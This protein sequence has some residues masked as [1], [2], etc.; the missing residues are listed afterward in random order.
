MRIL[1]IHNNYR[2]RGGEDESRE[3]EE[4]LLREMGHQVDV[5]E[6]NNNRITQLNSVQLS[7]KTIWSQE[8]YRIVQKSLRQSKRDVVHV[9]NF[10]PL[11]SP[12]VY[13]AAQ[14][15]GVPV[16]QTLRNYRLICPNGLFF[17]QNRVC[18]DCLDK[19]IPYPG[20]IH[21][22]YRKN[23]AA[24]SATVAMLTTHRVIQTWDKQVNLF[25][26]LSK[27]ARQKFIEAGFPADKII[28]KPNFVHPDPGVGQ[29]QGGYA[30][31]VGRLSVEKGLDILLAAWERLKAPIPLK[32]VGDG[33]LA[34][35]VIEATKR[36]PQVEWLGRKPMTEVY[37]LMGEAMFLIFPSKWYETF[38]RVAVEAFAKGTPVIAANLGAIAEL[39]ENER[40]GL[41]FCPSDAVDLA[42]KI[43]Q[44][45]TQPQK[46]SQMRREARAEFENKY[47]AQENYNQ[48]MK[49][50]ASVCSS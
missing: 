50:Y 32:I 14:S 20:I 44:I 17:R 34:Q 27:F 15:E 33:P 38:G 19:F 21:A 13:Y 30:L 1:S 5:Y 16:I 29:G 18:E 39:V 42:T 22:C 6:E 3:S 7:L 31:Y 9:Q 2:I 23:R 12:S 45:L 37:E 28:V 24:T 47:T 8:A 35:Q 26:S 46:L 40:T 36:F 11:I 48:L 10:F 25:I 4:R 49:I 43:D 41:H